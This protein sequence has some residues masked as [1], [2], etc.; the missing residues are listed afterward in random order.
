MSSIAAIRKEYML[1]TLTED[2]IELHPVRQFEKWW[3]Q[4]IDSKIDEVNA[5]TL[6]TVND[7]GKPS[8]RIVL[9]KGFDDNGF[10]FFTN[11]NSRKGMDI[12]YHPNACLVFFWKEL[13]RQVR[14][15]GYVK[16][17]EESESDIYFNSRPILSRI[18]A[19]ASPQSK[20]IDSREALEN[21]F[22]Q[23]EKE[24]SEK[25]VNRPTHWGGYIVQPEK[26]E[27]WQGRPNRMHDRI[28]YNMDANKQWHFVRLAP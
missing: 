15:E 12:K 10:T 3:Q 23:Y 17:I 2:D 20:Q 8:A 24:F 28:E 9:L 27:F 4:A 25:Q 6:A 19:W 11:Y 7:L 22:I 21:K 26:I 13:E 14:I 18:G 16:K 5:M 1:Q